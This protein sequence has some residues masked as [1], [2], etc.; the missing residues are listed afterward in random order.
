M[1]ARG[2]VRLSAALNSPPCE[3]CGNEDALVYAGGHVRC[4]RCASRVIREEGDVTRQFLAADPLA[5][6]RGIVNGVVIGAVLWALII[7]A[8]IR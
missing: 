3:D 4:Q 6:A 2:V 1:T 7:L 8:V 5:P